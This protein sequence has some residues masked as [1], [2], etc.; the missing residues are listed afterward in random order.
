MNGN[1]STNA[2]PMRKLQRLLLSITAGFSLIIAS[3][4]TLALP[5]DKD[6]PI[7]LKADSAEIDDQ[8]KVSVYIGNVFLKQGSME[9]RADK[10]TV[11][12]DDNGVKEMVAVGKPVNFRQ[13]GEVDGPWTKGYALKVEYF[14][15]IDEAIF[16]DKAKLIQDGDTFT[17]DRIRFEIEKDIVTATSHN[18]GSQ[19][20]MI[21]P[22]RKD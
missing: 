21:L 20:E 5:D 6:Q 2:Y 3:H 10:L 9:L 8:K 12:S 11:Y 7:N 14:A 1:N 17:G 13:Q 18:K 4:T 16:I 15:E 22:P 19:V